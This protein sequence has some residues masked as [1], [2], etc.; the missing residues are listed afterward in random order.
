MDAERWREIS[1]LAALAAEAAP[2]QREALLG[3][4]PEL[5]EEVESL[6]RYVDEGSGPLD[7]LPSPTE[8]VSP[9]LNRRIGAYRV[10][11]EL[12]RGGMGVVLLVQRDDGAFEQQA[13]VKLARVS[14][15]SEYFRRRFLEER[16]ILARLEHP[17]IARLLD[18]G[19]TE[20]GT[21]YLVMQF[22]EGDPL[23]RWCNAHALDVDS[24]IRLL[25]QIFQAVEF[26]HEQ[27]IVHRDL[28]PA[29]ILVTAEGR[30]V[31][32]DFG[33]AR[34]LDPGAGAAMETSMPMF[35]AR[36]ASPEQAQGV[37]ASVRSDVYSLGIVLYEL[38]T[39]A[40]PYRV[41]GENIPA[42][43][44]AVSEQ[45][46]VAPSEQ[47]A[48]SPSV[49]RRLAGDLDAILLKAIEKAPERRYG[50]VREF[51]ADLRRVLAG[52]AV[53]A[54][55]AGWTYRAGKFLRRHKWPVAAAGIVTLTLAS[56]TGYSIRQAQLAERERS[57][58]V[59]VAM[60][61]E[62]LLGASRRGGVSPL[63]NGGRNLKVVDVI[64]AASATI[65]EEFRDNPEVE[66]GLRSTVG[67]AF[68]A[69]GEA[70][71]ARPHIDRAVELSER[72]FGGSHH[73]TIR[74]LTA[75]ARSRMAAGDY[76]GAR[77]D[78]ERTLV[79][80]ESQDHPDTSFQRS[81]IAESFF[82]GGELGQAR[83]Q[84]ELALA[85]MR[86]QFGDRHVTTATMINN[87]AVVSDEAGDAASA[88]RYFSE[89]ANTLRTLPGPPGN[90][91]YP[92]FGLGR[93]H[94]FRGE[95]PAA[96]RLAEEAHAHARQTG[97]ERHPNTAVAAMQL[98]LVQAYA[99]DPRGEALGK[100][101]MTL[102]RSIHPAGHL[103]ISRGLAVYG[104]ILLAMDKPQ[105]ASAM[106][107]EAYRIARKVH[108]KDNWRPAESQLFL[109]AALSQLGQR[110]GARRALEAGV[111]EMR[112][113]LPESHPRVREA[114]RIQNRCLE[115]R[116]NR[117][118]TLP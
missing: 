11:R 19:L 86:K 58:A 76:A 39:G 61:L 101:M 41:E 99:G 32:L 35:T 59:Q 40:I 37:A 23:L 33:I 3:A 72:L 67:S 80:H 65:G 21:P 55:R 49:R 74:A 89:A 20:D 25:L 15:Q 97:G 53:E 93:A 78:L 94:F 9:Y 118:C 110:E 115:P 98:A 88:E 62:N 64:E 111:R 92:L 30:A 6:L 29:N 113:V 105:M 106:L 10:V 81:L 108:P 107:E 5:R 14:F 17:H 68:M 102:L 44:R 109:G 52:E 103:E 57:K 87:L 34:L 4:H 18:G 91:V 84:W 73:S 69:L 75:R 16:Q 83:H 22:V 96:L 45:D 100:D 77:R 38:L 36:Y 63:A 42:M 31:L 28:K 8:S 27:F 54:R 116:S 104:R 70:Q 56:A 43:L 26:A 47:V 66:A 79:W 85:S 112:A 51:G 50:T 13:A 71:R 82:R 60:F 117:R 12:G 2:E 95:Y 46:P 48:T 7:R 114:L 24:R 90:L 1:D